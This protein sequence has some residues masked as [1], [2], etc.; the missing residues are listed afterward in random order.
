MQEGNEKSNPLPTPHGDCD[1]TSLS[2]HTSVPSVSNGYLLST[3]AGQVVFQALRVDKGTRQ[4]DRSQML[5]F[6]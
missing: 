6:H 3:A 2:V 4:R 5:E 1:G